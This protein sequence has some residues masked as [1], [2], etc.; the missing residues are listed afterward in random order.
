M[1]SLHDYQG[2]SV[3]LNDIAALMLSL[4]SDKQSLLKQT[5]FG[6][7]KVRSLLDYLKDFGLV[8]EN[9]KH[10]TEL[11]EFLKKEDRN[12]SEDF[13]K[14]LCVYNWAKAQNNPALYFLL[15]FARDGQTS[16]KIGEDFKLWA[17]DN[18]V[19]T[20]YKKDFANKLLALSIK[21]LTEPEAFQSLTLVDVRQGETYRT[22]PYNVHTLLMGYVLYDNKKNRMSVSIP[23]LMDEPGNV[24][25]FFGY[26]EQTLNK[27]LDDLENLGLVQRIQNANLNMVQLSY[28]GRIIDFVERYYAEN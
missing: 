27:R 19:Q 18:K 10:L 9:K 22:Q 4:G 3:N 20:D 13:A 17:V 25:R 24:G 11:G 23:Q 8:N 21:A 26:S 2:F 14:W 28:E 12:L 6:D 7:N 16:S 15:N 5:G 1:Q